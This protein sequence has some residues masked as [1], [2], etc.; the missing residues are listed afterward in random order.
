MAD[1]KKNPKMQ[2]QKREED[3]RYERLQSWIVER[4][5]KERTL[6]KIWAL[7]DVIEKWA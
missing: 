2:K 4:P 7:F 1:D 6:K 3:E 5:L